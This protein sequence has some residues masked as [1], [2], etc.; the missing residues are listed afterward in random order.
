MKNR[1]DYLQILAMALLLIYVLSVFRII[2]PYI[3]YNLNYKYISNVLCQNKTK[4]EMNC[5][6][7]CHLQKELKKAANEEGQKK[8][9]SG[10]IQE[11]EALADNGPDLLFDQKF[12]FYKIKYPSF[13]EILHSV[14]ADKFT[15]PP[16]A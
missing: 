5:H 15:P 11:I 14:S 10:K 9:L 8:A 7:K 16:Q 4:P 2:Y 6:G 13:K 12:N 3:S 1:P